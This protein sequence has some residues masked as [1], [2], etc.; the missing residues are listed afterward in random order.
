MTSD[1]R[2]THTRSKVILLAGILLFA[3][4]LRAPFTSI[5]PLLETLKQTFDLSA[6]QAGLLI[7]LPLLSFSAVSPFAAGVARKLGLERALFL[8]LGIVAMGIAVRSGGHVALLYIGTAIIG[9]GIAIG[10]VLLPSLLKR[11]FPQHVAALTAVYVLTMGIAAA[12]ASAL[13]VPLAHLAG[14]DW[15]LVAAAALVLQAV[16]AVAWLPQL[17]R[18]AAAPSAAT[19]ESSSRALWRSPLAWQV[20]LFLG[21]DCFLYY[22]GVSWLPAILRDG[23]YS[24]EQAGSFHGVLLLATAFP[25][26][27][28]IPL[29]P[30]LRDQR[31]LA[32]VL[33]LSMSVG[34]AGLLLAPKWAMLW[35]LCFGFGAG[36]GLILALAFISLR[37]SG[38][39]QAAALSGM[40][41]CVG[42]LLAAAGPPLVGLLHDR[43]GHWAVPLLLCVTVGVLMAAVGLFAGR[44]VRVGEGVALTPR[45]S[46][47]GRGERIQINARS[48]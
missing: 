26:L 46:P 5:A 42:Y 36:G 40:A 16:A 28:L 18:G 33:S 47:G 17:S 15:R 32:V 27:L 21:L 45:P 19:A 29:V 1:T 8:A 39:G 25:G 14:F 44:S 13:A 38:A 11:D 10:N 37:T 4:N 12:S 20:T 23:G 2:R 48:V 24:A 31:A 43:S 7:T 3:A 9:S 41:Q 35:I 6:T 34:L 22:V 30:R